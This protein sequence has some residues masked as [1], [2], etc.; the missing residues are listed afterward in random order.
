MHSLLPVPG[1]GASGWDYALIPV[2]GPAIGAT[3]AG[4]LVKATAM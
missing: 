4:L 1:K 3:L 2:I